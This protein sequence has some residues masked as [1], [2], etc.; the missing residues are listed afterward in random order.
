MQSNNLPEMNISAVV[1]ER[2][3]EVKASTNLAKL[4]QELSETE[5]KIAKSRES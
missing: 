5:D 1:S 3:S 2:Y 4:Q